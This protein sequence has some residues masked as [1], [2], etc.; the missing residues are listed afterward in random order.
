MQSQPVVEY[1][2][3]GPYLLMVFSCRKGITKHMDEHD[4]FSVV[5]L[6]GHRWLF[7]VRCLLG[8]KHCQYNLAK[9]FS[10]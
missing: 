4:A 2:P 6:V 9:E 3:S 8:N 1:S 10:L 7:L 5:L